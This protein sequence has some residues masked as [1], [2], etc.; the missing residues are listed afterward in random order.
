M[1]IIPGLVQNWPEPRSAESIAAFANSS[2]FSAKAV[3]VKNTGFNDPI[4]A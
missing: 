3:G 1:T 4:S 2:D